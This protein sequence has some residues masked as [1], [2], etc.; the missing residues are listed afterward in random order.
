[1]NKVCPASCSGALT[2]YNRY[3]CKDMHEHCQIWA[4][5][6]ECKQKWSAANMKKY[7]PKACGTCGG[8]K[9]APQK[10]TDHSD[11]SEC[12]DS[13]A[14]CSYWAENGEC[15]SNPKYML[16][17]CAK[18]CGI[19]PEETPTNEIKEET[20][21]LLETT[22]EFG[23]KQ[24]AKGAEK[25][26]TLQVIRE[27]IEYMKGREVENLSPKIMEECLNRKELCAFWA[28]VGECSKNE[29]YMLVN[30]APSCKSC[31]LIDLDSRCPKLPD[32]V[33]ALKPGD[34]NKMFQRIV[35]TAP[36][37][38]TLS[39]E[40]RRELE[41]EGTPEYTVHVYSRPEATSWDTISK[42]EDK[43]NPPWIVVL[44]NFTTPEECQK[45]IDLGGEVGYER[46]K[47]VGSKQKF[48][49]S[50]DAVESRGRTSENAWC[51]ERSGCRN[52][53]VV[54]NVMNRMGRIL[55]IPPNNSEDLQM[56]RYEVGQFYN[57][58]HD[59]IG[60]QRDRQCGPRI[61]TVFMYLNEV[62]AGGGTRF[63]DLDMTVVPQVG[64]VL[65]WPSVYDSDPM[66]K[67]P[68]LT[69]EALPVEAGIKYGANG[70]IHMYDYLGP[71]SRGC[72]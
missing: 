58:H 34:L 18:S 16:T 21:D 48:D 38:R 41:A 9:D 40:E 67:D 46:S 31:H 15:D 25:Q 17:K 10:I 22:T 32:A 27:S 60:H 57:S 30:C 72:N 2:E 28:V 23:V 13:H 55:G 14:N 4:E 47:D 1:M 62:E 5:L 52:D 8:D 49:G 45:L 69:H 7:C 33:P 44:D 3:Q 20:E 42:E 66:N 35:E 53:P 71:Q 64:R 6:G 43:A 37:N 51:S 61:L 24:V 19:C 63:T 26:Q 29:A 68:R 65:I 39:D 50:F 54:Q 70:W 56:L 59:Y 36:G 12:E 11:D